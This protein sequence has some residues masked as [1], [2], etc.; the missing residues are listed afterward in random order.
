MLTRKTPRSVSTR[1]D[2]KAQDFARLALGEDFKRAAADFAVGG[3]LL[4][5]DGGVN[6]ERESLS[7]EGALDFFGNF[8]GAG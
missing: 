6:G 2:F 5:G 7:A 4:R 1:L 3:E 8:H